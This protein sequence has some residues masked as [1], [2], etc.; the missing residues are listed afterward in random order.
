MRFILPQVAALQCAEQR[1]S[2]WCRFHF[3]LLSLAGPG[4]LV[5][6]K[7]RMCLIAS[8]LMDHHKQ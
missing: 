4:A 8:L 1:D 7:V 2:F 6:E 3:V 5:V